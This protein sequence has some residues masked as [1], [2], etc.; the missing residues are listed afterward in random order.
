MVSLTLV[1][2]GSTKITRSPL[3]FMTAV[4]CIAQGAYDRT[5]EQTEQVQEYSRYHHTDHLNLLS[6][7]GEHPVA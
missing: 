2:L 7:D 1:F 3:A 5:K 6:Q 4:D